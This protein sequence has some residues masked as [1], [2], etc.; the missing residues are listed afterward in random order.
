MPPTRHTTHQMSKDLLS[1]ECICYL[2]T[3]AD[4]NFAIRR[5]LKF[6]PSRRYGPPLAHFSFH[7]LAHFVSHSR[8]ARLYELT[9]ST[10]PSNIWRTQSTNSPS[11]ASN[12]FKITRILL[13]DRP[14]TL[15][16]PWIRMHYHKGTPG[17]RRVDDSPMSL[18]I[19]AP[20]ALLQVAQAN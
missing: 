17:D 18:F 6:D 8:H 11:P 20:H 9:S 1:N 3:R 5:R 10:R 7:C 19:V 14:Q 15:H 4:S 13:Q 12:S 2:I 16:V